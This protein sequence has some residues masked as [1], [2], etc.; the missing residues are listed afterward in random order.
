MVRLVVIAL[1]WAV[2]FFPALL[3]AHVYQ[4]RTHPRVTD[5]DGYLDIGS[6]LLA[7][8]LLLGTVGAYFSLGWYDRRRDRGRP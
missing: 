8:W 7:V 3:V 1:T 2:A 5:T 6:V 4:E